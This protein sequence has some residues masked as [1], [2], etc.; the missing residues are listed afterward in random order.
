MFSGG[1]ATGTTFSWGEVG[2]ITLTPSVGDANYLGAGDV[3]GTTSGNVGRFV[4]FDFAVT[5]NAPLFDSGCSA[6]GKDAFTYIGE[7]F[8]YQTPP[9]ITVTARN[10][11]S[12]T[13]LNYSSD[14]FKITSVSLVGKTYTAATGALDPTGI[15]VIDPAIRYNGDAIAVPPPP[16][17]G[18]GTLTFSAGTGLL[19]TRAN[20]V[21]AFDAD[22][23][24][25]INV[26][27]ED[28]TTV[29]LV[30][31]IA[32]INPVQF[33]QATPGNGILFAG[34][35]VTAGKT[36]R[37]MRFGRLRMDN[38]SGATRLPLPLRVQAQY[39]TAYGFLS[40]GDDSC[41]GFSGTDIA[42]AFVP[43]NLVACETAV[44][45]AGAVTLVD[46]KAAGLQLAAP[47]TGND[48]SVDLTLNL[49]A[50]GGSICP[51]GAAT[52]AGLDFLQGNWGGGGVWNL[53]PGARATF[54]IYKDAAEFLY[55][56]EN[57]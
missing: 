22:I 41:T 48:G 21:V 16:A 26:V 15:P 56:Q 24:L 46:G 35:V 34:T 3:T 8:L 13:T 52:S 36:P 19:F 39:Y 47:G 43:G 6:A 57:Y 2:I 33:G 18:T 49:G 12:G 30:D 42:M 14:F 55:L 5:R 17:A 40:N 37:E 32:A 54:G 9:L 38:V 23:S 4:P 53:D 20:P 31:G 11:A 28:A 27:D 51:A 44:L 50:P 7:P 10:R 29:A 25:A 45:P 1:R